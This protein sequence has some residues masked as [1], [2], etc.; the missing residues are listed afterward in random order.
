MNMQ[1]L[2]FGQIP[3]II[4]FTLFM[5]IAKD[6]KE[7]RFRFLLLMAIGYLFLKYLAGL[8][9]TIL[10][11]I[12][13]TLLTFG[14]LK[15]LYKERAQITDIFLFVFS[16]AVLGLFSVPLLLLNTYLQNVYLCSMIAK[17]LGLLFI[18]VL[19][20]HLYKWYK[21]VCSLWNRNDHANRR[22]KSLTVRNIS[23]VFFNL[24]FFLMDVVLLFTKV[25]GV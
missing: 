2:I 8:K 13:H 17:A 11:P 15:S 7:K 25:G 1:E 12:F 22:I 19:R 16:M 6:L 24:V 18:F 23:M 4:Y 21:H 3:E 5:I 10:F 20:N 9:Y 14:I